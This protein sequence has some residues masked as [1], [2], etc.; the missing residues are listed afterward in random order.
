MHDRRLMPANGRVAHVSLQGLVTADRFVPGRWHRV[1]APVADLLIR[2]NGPRDRQLLFGARVLVLEEFEGHAF[3]QAERDG[4]VGYVAL[5]MLGPDAQ[6]SHWVSAPATH[7]Y[8]EPSIKTPEVARLS[9]GARLTIVTEH[10]QFAET[11]EGQFAIARH[12][13][14]IGAWADDPVAVAESLLGTPY[15]WGG[16][17]RDGIDCSGLVQL[18]LLACG[19][20]CPADSDLQQARLGRPLAEGEPPR[21]GD[22]IFWK[23]HVAFVSGPDRIIHANG[24]AMAAA[25]EGLQEAIDRIAATGEG[26]V[27]AMKRIAAPDG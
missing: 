12:I 23:G 7:L 8:P 14:P 26:A 17:S 27:T 5:G 22:L 18:S 2:P 11:A 4:Y 15:L 20:K 24:H 9:L 1:I 3:L 21:R 13:R 16:D 10:G 25:E 19:I 6:A